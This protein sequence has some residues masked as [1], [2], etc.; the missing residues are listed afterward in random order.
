MHV[1]GLFGLL[2]TLNWKKG[3]CDNYAKLHWHQVVD[4]LA[5]AVGSQFGVERLSFPVLFLI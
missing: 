4:A 3:L 2:Y 5:K 1:E